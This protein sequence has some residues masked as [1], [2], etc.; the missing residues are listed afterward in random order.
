MALFLTWLTP[1]LTSTMCR[2]RHIAKSLTWLKTHCEE[3]I[4][5]THKTLILAS[6]VKIDFMVNLLFFG[7]NSELSCDITVN[8]ATKTFVVS[9]EQTD[10][11]GRVKT[12]ANIS[13]F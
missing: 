5:N 11:L 2:I 13:D 1:R 6:A 4:F 9:P 12:M 8:T 3:G 10:G 7:T